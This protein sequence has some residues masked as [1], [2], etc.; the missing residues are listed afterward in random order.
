MLPTFAKLSVFKPFEE[1][2]HDTGVGDINS[3]Y[4]IVCP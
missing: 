3:G 4:R 2:C 1:P